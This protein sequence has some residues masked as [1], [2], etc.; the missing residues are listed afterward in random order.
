M[1]T[2]GN[3]WMTRAKVQG[4]GLKYVKTLILRCLFMYLKAPEQETASEKFELSFQGNVA[5][6]SGFDTHIYRCKM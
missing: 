5:S 2:G 1:A 3:L 6:E 4:K